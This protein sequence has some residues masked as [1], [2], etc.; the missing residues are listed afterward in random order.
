MNDHQPLIERIEALVDRDNRPDWED[1]V[2]RAEAPVDDG[3]VAHTGRAR[4]SYLA[5]RLVPV[6]V[7]AAAAFAFVLIAPWQHGRSFTDNAVAERALVAIGNEPV[8]HVVLRAPIG[9]GRTYID[10]ATGREAPQ[11]VTTEV[12][13]DRERRF[14]HRQDSIDG[15]L[16]ADLLRAPAET[17][18]KDPSGKPYIP[19]LDPALAEF[20]DGYRS[21]LEN[22][23]A[24]VTG[25]GTINGQNV[26][27][28]ELKSFVAER[29]A[30]DDTSSLP[31]RIEQFYRDKIE[32]AYDV[33]SIE[34]L[35]AGSG[36]FSS[37]L[38]R[39]SAYEI[40]PDRVVPITAAAAPE[41]LPGV[42][43]LGEKISTLPLADVKQKTLV[44]HQIE[45]TSARS[46]QTGIELRYGNGSPGHAAGGYVWLMETA[47]W[48]LRSSTDPYSELPAGSMLTVCGNSSNCDGTLIKN[49]IHV[50]IQAPSRELLLAAAR[51]LEPID[52]TSS[53]TTP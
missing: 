50:L 9:S 37:K 48:D 45:P 2:R 52:D 16:F 23:Y 6:F 47:K 38:L 15:H 11:L 12:W 35:P 10:L 8:L 4:R 14:V 30:V 41:A 26:T 46:S 32:L 29:I 36:N 24:H 13:Y 33:I 1:V 22:G 34:T 17:T 43:W 3:R 53:Q 20:F 49:G 25:T 18:G 39:G 19:Y 27:W 44:T 5:R 42:L 28:I 7:L 31:V 21:A 51:G 40:V